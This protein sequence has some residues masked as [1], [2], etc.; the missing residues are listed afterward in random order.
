MTNTG[1]VIFQ[2]RL[3]VG[4]LRHFNLTLLFNAEP[5]WTFF[6]R[7]S[8]NEHTRLKNPSYRRNRKNH[9]SVSPMNINLHKL[10]FLAGIWFLKFTPLCCTR[11]L[12]HKYFQLMIETFSF[13][14]HTILLKEAGTGSSRRHIQGSKI[15]KGLPSVNLQYSKIEKAKKKWTE[16]RAGAR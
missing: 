4:S 2:C 1:E 11:F 8:V 14:N 16:S 6:S 3:T 10:G 15:A 9:L 12:V 5:F 7:Y 13:S